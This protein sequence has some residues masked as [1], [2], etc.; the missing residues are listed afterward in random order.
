MAAFMDVPE[1][2]P[3]ASRVRDRSCDPT[4]ELN[5]LQLYRRYR[6]DRRGI[7][8]LTD[9]IRDVLPIVRN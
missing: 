8:E 9:K 1:D 7:F 6:L 4:E 3:T 2:N 5:D